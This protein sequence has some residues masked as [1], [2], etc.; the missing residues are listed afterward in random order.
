MSDR[1]PEGLSA[2]KTVEELSIRLF[3]PSIIYSLGY[4]NTDKMS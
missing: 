2:S 1:V 3:V 4:Q